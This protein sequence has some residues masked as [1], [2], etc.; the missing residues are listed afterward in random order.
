MLAYRNNLIDVLVKGIVKES[1]GYKGNVTY[2]R[3]NNEA[4]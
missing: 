2:C 4:I 3:Q 1:Q